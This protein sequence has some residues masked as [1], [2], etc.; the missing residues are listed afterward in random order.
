[1]KG[2]TIQKLD[3][4]LTQEAFERLLAWLDRDRDRAGQRYEEI[5]SQLIK[6]FVSRGCQVSEELADETINRVARKVKDIAGTYVGD[7]ALYFYGVAKMVYLEHLRRIPDVLPDPTPQ[8][9]ERDEARYECLQ[10]CIGQLTP[11]N[12]ELILAYYGEEQTNEDR[13]KEL[14]ER[15]GMKPNALWVR[16]HR[17]REKLRRCV[18]ECFKNR[19]AR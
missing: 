16:A 10:Q 4:G 2:S 12:R 18:S 1:M 15:M 9:T 5:R 6:I 11:D 13:R 19:Q 17:M 8:S 14:A 7:P 3:V